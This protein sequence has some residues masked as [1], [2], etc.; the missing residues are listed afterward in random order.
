MLSLLG[1]GFALARHEISNDFLRGKVGLSKDAE[2]IRSRLGIDKRFSVLSP[3][4]IA[5]T[6]NQNPAQAI[7]HARAHGET[8]VTL[9]VTAAKAAL[10]RARVEPS[11]VGLVIAN[12]DTPFDSVPAT[13]AQIA[14]AL[15]VGCGPH[16]DVNAACSSFAR[17]LQLLADMNPESLPDYVLCVQTSAYTVRTDYRAESIDG[18]IWS[19]G[20]AAQLLSP[21]KNGR[22]RVKPIVFDADPS[23]AEDIVMDAIG[24]FRQDGQKVRQFSVRKTCELLEQASEAFDV[25]LDDAYTVTHQANFVMQDSVIEHLG[26]PEG[27]F[28]RNVR[29]QGNIA[30]AGCPSVIA[31]HWDDFK[32]GDRIL[33]AV[34]GA[35]LA[36]GAGGLE[37]LS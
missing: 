33:Y 23:G 20:A 7:I 2:W 1:A 27:R 28:L 19:D 29:E 21:R 22:M 12:S 24:H 37:V 30:A 8:P 10:E 14:Q 3:D 18:F 35:G 9:G 25:E 34:V 32:K 36:W 13:A 15:G 26:I 5:K 16:Y 4:Y 6:K 11:R 31:Q 17:H